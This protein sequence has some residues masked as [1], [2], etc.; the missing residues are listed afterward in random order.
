MA[1]DQTNRMI[2]AGETPI[3]APRTIG[4]IEDELR[5]QKEWFEQL[6]RNL[7]HGKSALHG[8]VDRGGP[9]CWRPHILSM[10]GARTIYRTLIDTFRLDFLRRQWL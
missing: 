7:P 9:Y 8:T 2:V 1:P 3:D 5:L 10:T 6:F 4:S